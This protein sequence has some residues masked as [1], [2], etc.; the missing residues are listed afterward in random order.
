MPFHSLTVNCKLALWRSWTVVPLAF[1]IS[2]ILA[3]GSKQ[4]TKYAITGLLAQHNRVRQKF[5]RGD[6]PRLTSRAR[7]SR[8]CQWA[9]LLYTSPSP[10]D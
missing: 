2:R 1:D 10:R 9:C 3:D 6:A 5:V 7:R 4:A 8:T